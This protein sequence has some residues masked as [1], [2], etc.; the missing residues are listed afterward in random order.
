[1]GGS[2]HRRNSAPPSVAG[3][4]AVRST[5]R[6]AGLLTTAQVVVGLGNYGYS[7]M[8]ARL[9]APKLF[10][11]F[12]AAQGM[13]LVCGT[14]ATASVP[15][16][17]AQVF[18]TAS[19]PAAR[20]DVIW[21]SLVTNVLQG[22]VAAVVVVAVTSQFLSTG[23]AAWA[24][25]AAFAV[26]VVTT[27]AGAFQGDQRF[28]ALSVL[29]LVE[30]AL[31]VAFGLLLVTAGAGVAG[32]LAGA[33]LAAALV[34]AVGLVIIR[35][36]LRPQRSALRLGHLWRTSLGI[37]GVQG[38]VAVLSSLD[39][40]LVGVLDVDPVA[41]G[42]YQA[43]A[44]L[45]RVPL[46]LGGSLAT[47][48]YASLARGGSSARAV[49]AAVLRTY[50]FLGLGFLIVLLTAPE[51]ILSLVFPPKYALVNDFLPYTAL[52]GVGIGAVNVI[53]TWFQAG[54][55]FRTSFLLQAAA[56]TAAIPLLI[57][58]FALGGLHGLAVAAPVGPA[59]TAALLLAA[60]RET[61]PMVATWWRDAGMLALLLAAALLTR[62]W[63][64][65]WMSVAVLIGIVSLLRLLA[66]RKESP[67][68]A[69]YP[70]PRSP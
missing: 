38:F 37:V 26:F 47:A 56:L 44:I 57:V 6:G 49:M 31:K 21:F 12:A 33:A 62:A 35:H 46:F 28:V 7:L 17:V 64:P 51:P 70:P 41:A 50:G 10:G 53:T 8:L 48:V 42:S 59:I 67:R 13:V 4:G 60:A 1:M 5:M 22:A 16:V 34:A 19:G 69:V 58:G 11:N 15:W 68:P 25:A 52:A 29:R 18:A 9:L 55:K 30:V 40:V 3:G 39:V 54:A 2:K 36:D 24:A 63:P 61:W 27:P 23:D 14:L 20:R 45:G 43:S 66:V 32:A 65:L